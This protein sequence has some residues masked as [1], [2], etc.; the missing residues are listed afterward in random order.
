MWIRR[1]VLLKWCV[2]ATSTLVAWGQTPE[3]APAPFESRA[4]LAADSRALPTGPSDGLRTTWFQGREV[5][6]EV[7]DGWAVHDGDILLG[8]I[9]EI[10]SRSANGTSQSGAVLGPGRSRNLSAIDRQERLWPGGV[11]PYE[12]IEDATDLERE[13]IRLA[14]AEWEARTPIKFVPRSGQL[15][16]AR[17]VRPEGWTCSAYQGRAGSVS[18]VSTVGCGVPATV[19]ELGHTIGLGHEH[20]RPDRDKHM[21]LSPGD[22]GVLDPRELAL[23]R[24]SNPP[25]GPYDFRSTMHYQYVTFANV[26]S[27][28]PGMIG[29]GYGSIDGWLSE[30]DV[31]GVNR[32]YGRLPEATVISTNPPGLEIV[33]DGL[34]VAT[35][36]TFNWPAGSVHTLE[37]PLWQISVPDSRYRG[38]LGFDPRRFV[39][40]T[41]SDGGDRI[42]KFTIR[43]EE[44][45]IQA[46]FI[47]QRYRRYSN[48]EI[49]EP[50]LFPPAPSSFELDDPFEGFDASPRALSFVS[51]PGSELPSGVIRLTHRGSGQ[52]TYDIVSN[53]PWLVAEPTRAELAPGQSVDIEVQVLRDELGPET[54]RG[55]LTVRATGVDSLVGAELPRIPVAFVVLP[56]LVAVPLGENGE[57]IQVAVSDTEGFLG[58]DGHPLGRDG[59]VKAANGDIYRLAAGAGG[60]TATFEPGSQVL[61]LPGGGSVTLRQHAEGEWRIGEDRVQTGHR[62]VEEGHEH[63]LE[64]VLG[65]WQVA[66]YALRTVASACAKK[67]N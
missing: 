65:R 43:P 20:Q 51:A 23:L 6:Y 67:H 22:G 21:M 55:E 1:Q 60:I 53:N 54:Y 45:W 64:L 14:M 32:L 63:V 35:P 48:P 4:Q 57:S 7:I 50:M 2:V 37:A 46:S 10:E 34:R 38:P 49:Y 8:R 9:E 5:T 28:P 12:I 33:V 15:Q 40:G 11:I 58:A 24:R 29:G 59:L 27:I 31:D 61:D 62:Y 17:L 16:Y 47:S 66:A 25:K 56:D 41:W 13:E 3:Q 52:G 42:H 36:V 39:F 19:H 44:T 18:W 26:A 30:G